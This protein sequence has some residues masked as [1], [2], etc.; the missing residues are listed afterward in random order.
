VGVTWTYKNENEEQ[1]GGFA[2][3]IFEE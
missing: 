3:R 1:L 2:G